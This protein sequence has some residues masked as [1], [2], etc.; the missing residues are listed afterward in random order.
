M[1]QCVE[2]TGF[3]I[4]E[5]TKCVVMDY[6]GKCVVGLI[7]AKYRVSTS[8]VAKTLEVQKVSVANA[9][10]VLNL[11]GYPVGGMPFVGFPAIRLVDN[12]IFDLE[13]IYTGGGSDRSLLKLWVSEI[14]Q[15]EPIITRIRK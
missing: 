10:L 2:I 11:T 3:P 1:D 4:E 15:M 7:P 13:Y 5:I 14:E 6:D 8:R 12:N 9:E